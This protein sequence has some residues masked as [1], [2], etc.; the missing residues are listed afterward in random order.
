MLVTGG[1]GFI[2][3]HLVDRLVLD[4]FHVGVLDNFGKGDWKGSSHGKNPCIHRGDVTDRD[5]VKGVVKEYD[6]I[7][8]EAALVS[9]EMSTK[10][11]ASLHATNV[12]GTINLLSAAAKSNIERFVYA[13]SAAVYGETFDGLVKE[14]DFPNPISPYG[15]SKLEGEKYCR[16]FG[17]MYGFR[18]VCLRYFNVYG[19]RQRPGPYGGVISTFTQRL[20]NGE[21]PVIFGNGAQ[22]R[23]FVHVSDVVEANLLA[24]RSKLPPGE[25]FNISTG[26]PTR[27]SL[28][29]SR[30]CE[31]TGRTSVKPI[32][33]PGRTG[34]IKYSCGDFAKA[35]ELLGYSP[36]VQLHEGLKE[37]LLSV[38][39]H[40]RATPLPT[41]T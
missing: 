16:F 2:G 3:S 7:F 33:A 24:L 8:H 32:H 23:D 19:P 28:L 20:V 41:Q 26:K 4:G 38:Q 1:A 9:T 15:F 10:D 11:L 21:A 17:T 37:L 13:S 36:R 30:L 40:E 5:F 14:E 34:D 22:T 35:K 29:A 27:I 12:D 18:T 39:G 6:I 25:A 31:L